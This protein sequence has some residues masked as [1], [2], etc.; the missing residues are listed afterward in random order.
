MPSTRSPISRASQAE[1]FVAGL[2]EDAG[3]TIDTAPE[4]D[5]DRVDLSVHRGNQRYAVE[6]KSS[7]GRADRVVPLLAQAI[8]QAQT[9]ATQERGAA[10]LA[11]VYVD[12]VSPALL[13]QVMAFAERFAPH[14]A[15]GIVSEEGPNH[16]HG[17]GLDDLQESPRPRLLARHAPARPAPAI[18]LFSD[19][20]Q[21]ML[22]VLLA[23]ELPEGLL[24]APRGRYCSGAELAAAAQVS[25]MS[26]S[27]FLTQLG[28]ENFLDRSSSH[29]RLVR[30]RE[31]FSRWSAA[32]TRPGTEI[33]ARF[34]VR[35]PVPL[36][37]R[38]LLDRAPGER[39]LGLFAA[40]DALKL[41]HVSGVPPHVFVRKLPRSGFAASEDWDML[42]AFPEGTPDIIVRQAPWPESI[43]R[44]ATNHDGLLTADAIQVW[45]DVSSHPSRGKEQAELIYQEVLQPLIEEGL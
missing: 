26:A 23:P 1:R 22:K 29:L 3:W 41:G 28:N 27:R 12:H 5:D 35:V 19:L 36:Q 17:P 39:C 30:R 25:A 16:F 7:Q 32:A 33:P 6:I 10:P 13:R 18:N 34:L 37:M 21:W 42:A 31:L 9:L 45:L 24:N 38:E 14:V 2:F 40:A 11:L 20:N 8:L 4:G 43:F 15:F 44:G